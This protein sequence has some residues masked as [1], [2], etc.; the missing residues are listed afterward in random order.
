MAAK[1][2]KPYAAWL[3]SWRRSGAAV[4]PAKIFLLVVHWTDATFSS[5]KH[6]KGDPGT[7]DIFTVGF[8]IAADDQRIVIAGEVHDDE[9][10]RD[11]T[12]V[13]AG[14]INSVAV[15]GAISKRDA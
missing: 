3:K 4:W 6:E 13:P 9:G 15:L 10:S 12:T 2:P 1:T 11:H 14:I 8:L 7:V 5:E